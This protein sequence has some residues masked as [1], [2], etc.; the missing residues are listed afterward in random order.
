MSI[1]AYVIE[2]RRGN[3]AKPMCHDTC[4]G[5]VFNRSTAQPGHAM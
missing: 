3:E 2:I 4:I 1:F 5:N